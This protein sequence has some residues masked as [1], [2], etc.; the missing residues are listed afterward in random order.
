MQTSSPF[1]HSSERLSFMSDLLQISLFGCIG[2][3]LPDVLRLLKNSEERES[4]GKNLPTFLG[5][6]VLQVF[7][8]GLVAFLAT[9]ANLLPGEGQIVPGTLLAAVSYGFSA[10]EILT[11]LLATSAPKL[12]PSSQ[13]KSN[14]NL[15]HWWAT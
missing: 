9:S 8:G 4:V 10:P 2:G 14:F 1:D 13:R 6:L 5:G 3:L 7:L 12:D 11:R 15:L